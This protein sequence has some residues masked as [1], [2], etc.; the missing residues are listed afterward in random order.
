MAGY[1]LEDSDFDEFLESSS[2]DEIELPLAPPPP[3]AA[4]AGPALTVLLTSTAQRQPAVGPSGD[5]CVI[6]PPSRSE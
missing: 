3:A 4:P 2:E 5:A 1:G 6:V